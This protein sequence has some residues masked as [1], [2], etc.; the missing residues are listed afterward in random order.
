MKGIVKLFCF[1]PFFLDFWPPTGR[2]MRV[3]VMIATPSRYAPR[4]THSTGHG[5]LVLVGDL[6]RFDLELVITVLS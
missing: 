3:V 5:D 1:F 2:K 4:K 6:F